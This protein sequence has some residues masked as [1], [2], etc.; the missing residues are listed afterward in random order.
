MS[1]VTGITFTCPHCSQSLEA[2][3]DMAGQTIECPACQKAISIPSPRPA[4]PHLSLRDRPTQR[5]APQPPTCA[6]KY[7]GAQH[8]PDAVFCVGCGRNLRTGNPIQARV[9]RSNRNAPPSQPIISTGAV[10]LLIVLAGGGYFI[11]QHMTRTPSP[12]VVRA[13]QPPPQPQQPQNQQENAAPSPDQQITDAVRR[14]ENARTYDEAIP[15]LKS[16]LSS[17]PNA[18]NADKARSLLIRLEHE[19][20][21]ATRSRL[22]ET[23]Q[24][25]DERYGSPTR[26]G[27]SQGNEYWVP[28][29]SRSYSRDGIDISI[30]FVNGRASRIS[31]T[32]R[33]NIF[34]TDKAVQ[35]LNSNTQGYRWSDAVKIAGSLEID[36]SG[37]HIEWYRA[38]GGMANLTTFRNDMGDGSVLTCLEVFS[39]DIRPGMAR[40]YQAL[41]QK[42]T[43]QGDIR[44]L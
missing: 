21:A 29:T 8:A 16:V 26:T 17:F 38:D 11:W 3:S 9:E 33:R 1:E 22:G 23:V 40:Q 32:G 42:Y 41:F 25:C 31:Y 12:P 44:G 13:S 39:P 24:Q 7:C 15:L 6:C 2:E 14:A 20:E 5:P 28:S 30:N 35:L 37:G 4:K 36:I 10:L 27:S 34:T 18:S 43:Q 19:Y